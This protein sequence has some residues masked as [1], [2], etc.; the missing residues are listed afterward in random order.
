LQD[1]VDTQLSDNIVIMMNT[2]GP[3]PE[4][5]N[6]FLHVKDMAEKWI[7]ETIR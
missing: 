4:D 7:Q 2:L 1:Q 3:I 5:E 6:A